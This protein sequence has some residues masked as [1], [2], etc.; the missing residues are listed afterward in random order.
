VAVAGTAVAA[1]VGGTAVGASVAGTATVLVGAAGA[2]AGALVATAGVAVAAGAQA[3]RTIVMKII[4]VNI[5]KNFLFA[6]ILSS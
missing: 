3:D 5:L 2:V 6:D 4:T 1:S